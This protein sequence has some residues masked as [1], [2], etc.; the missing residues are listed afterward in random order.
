M[1]TTENLTD[2]QHMTGGERAAARG[3]HYIEE[4][5]SVYLMRD[6]AGTNTWV[7]DPANFDV[8]LETNYDMPSNAECPCAV[9]EECAEIRHRMHFAPTP[10]GEELMH[11]LADAL[12]YTVTK[13]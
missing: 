1:T 10:D 8:A 9:P 3:A 12:G 11:M 13:P 4:S 7:I 2:E 6:L 5:V